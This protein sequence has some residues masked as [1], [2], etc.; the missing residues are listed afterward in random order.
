MRRWQWPLVLSL[1]AV[2]G[3]AVVASS[4]SDKADNANNANNANKSVIAHR[5]ASGYLPEHTLAAKAMAHAQGAD[6]L[7]QDLVM[8]KDAQVVVLHDLTLNAIS[9]VAVKF[10]NRARLD[11]KHHVIDFTL[12]ELR[13]LKVNERRDANG[14][15]LYPDRFRVQQALFEIHTLSE[16]IE[17]IQSLNRTTGQRVGLYAEIKSPALHHKEGYDLARATLEILQSHGYTTRDD[18][19]VIQSFDAVE[20]QRIKNELLP[21]LGIDLPLTQLLA[22]PRWGVSIGSPSDERWQPDDL[23][24]VA[25]YA[26]ALG[27][28][29]SML[30][31]PVTGRTLSSEAS[32]VPTDLS[33]A[34][35]STALVQ[36][37]HAHGLATHAFTLRADQLPLDQGT[38][39]DWHDWLFKRAQIDG[40]FVDFPDLTVQ[41]L[42]Q[43]Q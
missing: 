17:L 40:I 27:V 36:Q 12:A 10:P 3:E 1:C 33:Q 24:T 29:L 20:L 14:E 35:T 22:D 11:G 26:D 43:G 18:G 31:D 30:F 28:P 4:D 19:A 8:T 32:K 34:I 16:E 7:E 6:Y 21:D 15:A 39:E 13:T 23:V 9:D 41:Y 42:K 37:A 38:L 25:S 5:G 2:V